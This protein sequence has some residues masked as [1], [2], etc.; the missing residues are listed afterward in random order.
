MLS[1]ARWSITAPMKLRKSWTSPILI[2]RDH[3]HDAVAHVG[4]DRPR[5]VDAA[6]GRALLPLVLEGAAHDGHRQRLGV[7]RRVGDD[8][9][10]AAGLAHDARVGAVAVD[11]GADRAPHRVE[12]VGGAGEVHAGE[13]A[14]VEHDLGISA[15]S[16]GTRLMTPGGRPASSSSLM[17]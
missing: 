2:S 11:L 3:G 15:A 10:L 16:P 4:P 12:D 6:R 13:V 17:M 1:K 5:H 9:V 14:V 8:E 7:G